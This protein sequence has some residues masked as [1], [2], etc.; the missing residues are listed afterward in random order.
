M[1]ENRQKTQQEP[2]PEVAMIPMPL[3][4]SGNSHDNRAFDDASGKASPAT[5][6]RSNPYTN[7]Q[8]PSAPPGDTQY[9]YGAVGDDIDYEPT[10]MYESLEDGVDPEEPIAYE[11][12]EPVKPVR[13]PKPNLRVN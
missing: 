1:C 6:T 9:A 4:A 3:T 11:V 13:Q 10:D 2:R 5:N 7:V 8:L 12:V